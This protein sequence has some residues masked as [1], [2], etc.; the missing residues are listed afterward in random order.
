M[1]T[2]YSVDAETGSTS[3]THE[4]DAAPVS[5]PTV[6]NGLVYVLADSA[7]HAVDR[8]DGT[9][10]WSS[11]TDP[12]EDNVTATTEAVYVGGGTLD[13]FDAT[14]GDL[15]WQRLIDGY[16]GGFGVPVVVDGYLYVGV[17]VKE[18]EKSIYDNYVYLLG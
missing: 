5:K 15:A 17:C 11:P 7:L 14:T 4:F 13:V 6:G 2:L 3:W 12:V 18:N 10:R 9:H 16:T 8:A 1:G